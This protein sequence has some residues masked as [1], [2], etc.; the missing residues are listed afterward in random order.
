MAHNVQMYIP[1]V[2][3]YYQDL[4]GCIMAEFILNDNKKNG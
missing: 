1:M 4:Q 3:L 2:H